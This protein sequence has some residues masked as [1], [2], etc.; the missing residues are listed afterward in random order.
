MSKEEQKFLQEYNIRDFDIPLVSVDMA[1]FS[2][3]NNELSILLVERQDHPAKGMP[4][5]PGGFVDLKKDKNLDET[6]H[7]KLAEKTGIRS[8]YLEQVKSIGD[9]KRDPRGWSV[10]VLYFALID[11][12]K[13]K[14]NA[15]SDDAAWVT[16]GEA[17]SMK[18]AFDHKHLLERAY[19]RLQSKACYTT[20]PLALLPKE[21]T[22]TECQTI[23]EII[24]GK[25]LQAKSFRKRM[26]DAEVVSETGKEKRAG[27]RNAA[28]FKATPNTQSYIFTRPLLV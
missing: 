16:L 17:K 19:D 6:A 27:K 8:P 22:L 2:I 23:F 5:L 26:L 24:L 13:I 12:N 10:T 15:L 14:A 9:L 25:T 20:L 21:F 28:L 1:I 3:I 7:R 4:A 18:L 11:G